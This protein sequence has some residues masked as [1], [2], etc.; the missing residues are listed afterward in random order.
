MR[1]RH[2]DNVSYNSASVDSP[3]SEQLKAHVTTSGHLNMICIIWQLR[4][5][6]NVEATPL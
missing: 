1:A 5:L 2:L 6:G 3:F 4:R